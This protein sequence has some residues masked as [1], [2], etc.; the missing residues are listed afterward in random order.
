[1]PEPAA[2]AEF[3][4]VARADDGASAERELGDDRRN[5]VIADEHV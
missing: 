2:I 4:A 1:M 5:A 3:V